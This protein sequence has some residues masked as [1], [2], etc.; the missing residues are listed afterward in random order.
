VIYVFDRSMQVDYLLRPKV[1]CLLKAKSLR[2]VAKVTVV[3][4]R[5][6]LSAQH[7]TR[8]LLSNT[9]FHPPIPLSSTSSS[10]RLPPHDRPEGHHH[11]LGIHRGTGTTGE[12]ACQCHIRSVFLFLIALLSLALLRLTDFT[13]S[14]TGSQ[15]A[16]SK[17]V[18]R[19]K[20][21]P[22]P[23]HIADR[24]NSPLACIPLG[25]ILTADVPLMQHSAQAAWAT[26]ANPSTLV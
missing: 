9:S 23:R 13:H 6:L 10:N 26:F 16:L 17:E 4:S 12:G 18:R 8:S 2:L 5:V 25:Y 1:S 21:H 14:L 20:G 11:C 15:G 19:G 22:L 3:R 24:L 7:N